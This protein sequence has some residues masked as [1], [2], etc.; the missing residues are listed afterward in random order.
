[1]TNQFPVRNFNV[2]PPKLALK[3]SVVAKTAFKHRLLQQMQWTGW[4]VQ[5]GSKIKILNVADCFSIGY[6]LVFQCCAK[7]NHFLSTFPAG[8][9]QS[10]RL[11]MPVV[12]ILRM[13]LTNGWNICN[14]NL[15]L[16]MSFVRIWWHQEMRPWVC[17]AQFIWSF[18]LLTFSKWASNCAA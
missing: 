1:M 18:Q 4:H 3:N 12:S 8:A 11:S 2:K 16:E 5:Q 15:R 14:H 17:C 9:L 6:N 10:W 13:H 7:P